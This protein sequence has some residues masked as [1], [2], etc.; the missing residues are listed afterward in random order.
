M[1]YNTGNPIG[2]TSPKDLSDN[3]RNLDLLL[4]GDD[5]SYPDRKGVSRKSWKGMEAEYVADRLRR[6]TEF[7]TAQTDRE[8]QFAKFLES[9]GF[10]APVPYAPG[11]ILQRATQTVTYLGKEYRV[12]SQFLPLLT[13]NWAGDES[14]L[15]L[16]GDDSLRQDMANFTDP[17]KGAAILGRGVVSVASIADLL[18]ATRKESLTYR[19]TSYHEWT[20][21]TSHLGPLGGGDFKWLTNSTAPADGGVILQVPGVTVG[22]FLRIAD[23]TS[24][25]A[26]WY[27]ALGD[28]AIDDTATLRMV[29]RSE[30]PYENDY[31]YTFKKPG[32]RKIVLRPGGN[33]KITAPIY[34]R[35]GDWLEGGGYTATRIFSNQVGIGQLIYA[36]WG[37][38]DGV[39]VKDPG[40]LIP[41]VTDICFAETVGGVS[42]IYLD[43][44]S[45]WDIRD[46]WFF[47]DVGVRTKGITNDGFMLNCV[48]DNGSGHLAIFEGTGDGFHTGQST[49]LQNCSAF[50]T[51]YGGIKLDG[52]SDVTIIGG[53]LNFIP[54]YGLYTGTVKTNSRIKAI[55]VNFKGSMTG[56]GMDVTQQHVRVTAPTAGFALIDCGFAYSRNA[57]IQANYPVQVRGGHSANAAIDSIVCLGGRSKLNGMTFADTGRH[58]VRSTVRIDVEGLEMENPLSIGVPADIFARGAIYLSGSG[59]KSTVF[60]CHRHDDKGPAVSTNGLNGIRSS[61]NT[62]EGDVDVLHYTG[63]GVNYSVNERAENPVGLWRNVELLRGGYTRWIESSGR[64]R[65]KNGDPTSEADGTVVGAQA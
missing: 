5:P 7:N 62:S 38:V 17:A 50:K 46:C 6:A 16:I 12:K 19:V 9:S 18:T 63:N 52:V 54:F 64:F 2:S 34:L 60:N 8:I 39:L 22:R 30:V 3:A 24:V 51:R 42:A 31:G 14:K 10:E 13:T 37:L 32:G 59:S 29:C 49:V 23:I 56:E 20:L 11:L 44:I 26:E 41:K 45:G 36:G 53:F 28:G 33:Y 65:I 40:G 61:G 25:K 1:A 35:K 47:A 55:G 4:L 43:N 15:K 21:T 48:A 27:G 58:P 57:D